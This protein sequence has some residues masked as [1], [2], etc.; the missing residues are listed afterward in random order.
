MNSNSHEA[1]DSERQRL[2]AEEDRRGF[3]KVVVAAGVAMFAMLFLLLS[4]LLME[5]QRVM[6]LHSHHLVSNALLV[7]PLPQAAAG[8]G[9]QTAGV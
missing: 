4:V 7:P 6:P 3:F 5:G 1:F 9:W 8:N 2:M